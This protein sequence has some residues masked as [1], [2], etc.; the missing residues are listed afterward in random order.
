MDQ[1]EIVQLLGSWSEKKGALYEQLAH[2]IEDAIRAG[3]LPVETRL[4]AERWLAQHLGISR[5]TVVAAYSLLQEKGWVISKRGSGTIVSTL[6][7]QRSLRLRSEQLKPL[8]RGPVIDS[9]LSSQIE[10]IDLSTGAPAWPT[11]FDTELCSIPNDQMLPLLDEYGYVPQG[12]PQ[13]REMIARSE[14]RR[15]GKE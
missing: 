14:E 3:E 6:S 5:S 8:A 10:S 7:P 9:Y 11:G 1:R 15:V 12:L 4:P 13:L 2:A